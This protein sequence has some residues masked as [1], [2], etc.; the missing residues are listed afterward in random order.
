MN[1]NLKLNYQI[2]L[3]FSLLL[4][5]SCNNK[6]NK[7]G[8]KSITTEGN[9]T[10]NEDTTNT[11]DDVSNSTPFDIISKF[12][13]VYLP[14][15]SKFG[16]EID[17]D[18]YQIVTPED[19]LMFN[20]VTGTTNLDNESDYFYGNYINFYN[21]DYVGFTLLYSPR[22]YIEFGG[23]KEI[24][25]LFSGN[26]FVT[27][28]DLYE[29]Q[30]FYGASFAKIFVS[31][32]TISIR[33]E[34]Y[35]YYKESG[36][37]NEKSSEQTFFTLTKNNKFEEADVSKIYDNNSFE[38]FYSLSKQRMD[39]PINLHKYIKIFEE[40]HTESFE[41]DKLSIKSVFHFNVNENENS[42]IFYITDSMQNT[43]VYNKFNNAGE[44]L[45]NMVV[46]DCMSGTCADFKVTDINIFTSLWCEISSKHAA[47]KYMQYRY[48]HDGGGNITIFGTIEADYPQY[49]DDENKNYFYK[50]IDDNEIYAFA[51]NNNITKLLSKL[52]SETNKNDAL[53]YNIQRLVDLK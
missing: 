52:E 25:F 10:I 49:K 9:Q 23:L 53:D 30:G 47:G 43:F 3:L 7:Q 42:F 22:E 19:I 11:H 16:E 4:I 41:Q 38:Y 32:N 34:N 27:S 29:H 26:D 21:N 17:E 28:H 46:A 31:K 36:T 8:E 51:M 20:N 39:I 48:I 33:H 40:L 5:F 24:L 14:Y 44:L 45:A 6:N 2:L 37:F 35:L 15:N 18:K 50:L 12:T 1:K 13:E